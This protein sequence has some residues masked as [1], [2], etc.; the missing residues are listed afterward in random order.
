MHLPHPI[1]NEQSVFI[2]KDNVGI[3]SNTRDGR[4][5]FHEA[6]TVVYQSV[7]NNKGNI[8]N[9]NMKLENFSD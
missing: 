6:T 4:N 5:E 3:E 8:S 7:K 1:V 9:L 2:E